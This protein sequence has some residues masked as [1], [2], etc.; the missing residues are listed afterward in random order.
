[1]KKINFKFDISGKKIFFAISFIFFIY[2]LYLSIPSLYDTGRVQ[3]DIIKKLDKDFK[4]NFS[5]ST[6]I[7]YRILPKPHFLIK[8]C[9][10][11][12]LKSN[13]VNRIAEIQDLKIYIDQGNFFNKKININNLRISNANFFLTK[14]N[15][16]YIKSLVEDK[17]S[18]K[19][20]KV[21][22]SKIFFK[23][24]DEEVIFIY[25]IKDIKVKYDEE[26]N[27]NNLFINGKLFNI[28]NKIDWSINFDTKKKLTKINAKKIFLNFQNEAIFKKDIYEYKNSLEIQSNKFKTNYKI[29]DD[30]IS[31]FSEK[32]LIKNTI[33][34]YKG[35]V[36]LNPFNLSL[37]IKSKKI[38]LNYFFKN[39][40]LFY[41]IL[42][43]K[44]FF[45]R[46]LY[47]E[48][49]IEADHL[50]KA[51]I[52]KKVNLN[53]NL[54]GGEINLNNS[55]FISDKI[56][57]LKLYNSRFTSDNNTLLFESSSKLNIKDL[58]FFYKYFL[59]PKKNRIELKSIDIS[60]QINPKNGII[61]IN[62]IRL[63]DNINKAI[64]PKLSDDLLREYD[65][66]EFSYLN[67]IQFKNFLKNFFVNYLLEG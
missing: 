15:F 42:L 46:N 14:S 2:L 48:I 7:R 6:D 11:I 64:K 66:E 61:K 24:K 40:N 36:D 25:T 35:N 16:N 27:K 37:E 56:G 55:T 10:L 5:L 58:N 63:Y 54:Q 3:K 30:K 31:F 19:E 12:E 62:K 59:I 9:E 67:P 20:I 44:I 17:F 45:K 50:A 43:S 60:F 1:M 39:L 57:T 29:Q 4:L 41:E 51:K 47:A 22:K 32:S 23:D 18:K 26:S 65:D 28:D 21:N 38:D 52:F 33:I 8:D 34:N 13:V 53:I 49:K